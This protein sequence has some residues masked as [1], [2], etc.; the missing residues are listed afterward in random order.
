MNWG[1]DSHFL[2]QKKSFAKIKNLKDSQLVE[3]SFKEYVNY[4]MPFYFFECE[5]F[6]MGLQSKGYGISRDSLG[7]ARKSFAEAWERLWFE[8]I[9]TMTE[10]SSVISSNGF[11]AGPNSEIAVKTAK[12]ELIERAVLQIAWSDYIGWRKISTNCIRSHILIAAFRL[13]GWRLKLYN[14][15]SN[16][17]LV[18]ACVGFHSSLGVV[19]DTSFV[20]NNAEAESKVIESVIKSILFQKIQKNYIF[21]DIGNPEDHR[22]FYA[23]PENSKAFNFLE[24]FQ[25]FSSS[26]LLTNVEKTEIEILHESDTFPAV[27]YAKNIFWPKISWGKRSI[28]GINKWPHPLA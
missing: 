10:Y 16:L 18:K 17:G 1:G 28:Q 11:A 5:M 22:L 15:Q 20:F 27:V 2:N 14:M 7:A 25:S 13:K 8:K 19:F 12:A 4:Q 3:W 21:P 9:S 6:G 26:V 24:N 23:E